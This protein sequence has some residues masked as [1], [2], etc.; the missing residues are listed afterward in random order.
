MLAVVVLCDGLCRVFVRPFHSLL[1]VP[2]SCNVQENARLTF[3]R[4]ETTVQDEFK[5]AKLT[6]IENNGR[7]L[8]SLLGELLAARSIAGNKVLELTTYRRK[9]G[10]YAES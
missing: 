9:S 2:D 7:K 8:F 10:Q 3:K 6:L 4:R 1:P 5:I